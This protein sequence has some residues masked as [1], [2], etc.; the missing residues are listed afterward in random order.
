MEKTI[1]K[2]IIK[3]Y[4][5][6]LFYF[7]FFDYT[8]FNIFAFFIFA[9]FYIFKSTYK[10]KKIENSLLIISPFLFY[11]KKLF[12][13]LSNNIDLWNKTSN[14]Y[15]PFTFADLKLTLEQLQCQSQQLLLLEDNFQSMTENCYFGTWRYGPLFHLLKIQTNYSIVENLTPFVFY[16]LFLFF[17]YII[18]K[19]TNLTS[20]EFNLIALSP[21]VNL[22]L[23]Q[24]NLDIALLLIVFYSL[25]YYRKFPNTI[26]FIYF[27][28]ALIKQHPIGLIIGL[29]FASKNL[30]SLKKAIIYLISFI[31]INLYFFLIDIN[32]LSGQARP[33]QSQVSSGLLSMSQYLWVNIFDRAIGFRLVLLIMILFI[34][35]ILMLLVLRKKK[36]IIEINK[37]EYSDSDLFEGIVAWFVFVFL[38]ANYDYR[39]TIL[40]ILFIFLNFTKTQKFPIIAFL[41]IAP[42]SSSLPIVFIYTFTFIKYILSIVVM[43]FCVELMMEQDRKY[44]KFL[45][46]FIR[47]RE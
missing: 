25:K 22:T 4:L 31:G 19:K 10:I 24:L 20:F 46:V 34:L 33:N 40:I 43:Y 1:S 45:N 30:A 6:S 9:L 38:Y 35:L 7:I 28:L 14:F 12:F 5:F 41:L 18:Y 47:N 21:T 23:T 27:L 16:F 44:F 37:N 26:L 15:T 39:N 36:L 42:F 17:L 3:L 2:L 29:L 32:Y 8:Y 11:I 13:G